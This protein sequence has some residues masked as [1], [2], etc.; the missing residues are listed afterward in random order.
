M[1]SEQRLAVVSNQPGDLQITIDGLRLAIDG[2][3]ATSASLPTLFV[4]APLSKAPNDPAAAIAEWREQTR[5]LIDAYQ[6]FEGPALMLNIASIQKAPAKCLT[7]IN[8][9][10]LL[11]EPV[12]QIELSLAEQDAVW[13]LVLESLLKS[14]LDTLLV[15]E[16]VSALCTPVDGQ[17]GLELEA[18]AEL[19]HAAITALSSSSVSGTAQ[20][21]KLDELASE[22]ELL[23]LQLHQVQEELEKHYL[24]SQEHEKEA[25]SQA[26]KGAAAAAT[27]VARD[28]EIAT[29]KSAIAAKEG[30]I[31]GLGEK[32]RAT[33]QQLKS[34]S[35]QHQNALAA[36][37]ALKMR[38]FASANE[39]QQK[40]A[41]QLKAAHMAAMA[42]LKTS[43]E[44]EKQSLA[45]S[46]NAVKKQLSESE[47]QNEEIRQ[48]N[49]LLLLQL[50]QVQEELERY[51]LQFSEM[52]TYAAL[53]SAAD[54]VKSI[55]PLRMGEVR[56]FMK[57]LFDRAY[58]FQQAG[59]MRFPQL[60]YRL[61]GWKSGYDPHPLFD[62][63][64]YLS[65]IGLTLDTV[66]MPPLLHYLRI[67]VRLNVSPHP[68]FD[69]RWYKSQYPDVASSHI[70]MLIHFSAHG[71]QE[72]RRPNRDFDC[73]W[74]LNQYPDV[75]ELGM[76]PLAHYVLHGKAEGRRRNASEG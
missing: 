76:N 37:E 7:L 15:Q 27:I 62:T 65:Q 29:L 53:D 60:H 26:Q 36:A 34:L 30:E 21:A 25:Q 33:E 58:Y 4:L 71:W 31:K 13:A 45:A 35:E 1:D 2:A 24:A 42:E 18:A 68:E 12:Q 3:D 47:A 66:D 59:E 44:N 5:T 73:D 9:N 22:N 70:P 61:S 55:K 38:T 19:A 40:A 75:A 41:E 10:L 11:E 46:L 72:G 67:G 57:H 8:E 43:G 50:H 52:Q 14:D 63:E 16:E 49:E 6:A 39:T 56:D 69:A 48:E 28:K 64:Y 17:E 20:S 23:L 32:L 74:Y 54:Q 51:Y